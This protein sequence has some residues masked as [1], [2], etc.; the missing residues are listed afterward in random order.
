MICL[1][2][3]IYTRGGQT[4]AACQNDFKLY[5][6]GNSIGHQWLDVACHECTKKAVAGDRDLLP[7]WRFILTS[8]DAG[9]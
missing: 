1:I 9:H 4:G 3:Q 6:D 5:N 8:H 7:S 2:S